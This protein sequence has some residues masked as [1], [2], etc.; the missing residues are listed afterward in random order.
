[1][2]G[3]LRPIGSLSDPLGGGID[4]QRLGAA[5][6]MT[7]VDRELQ[8]LSDTVHAIEDRTKRVT[9]CERVTRICHV[10]E[11]LQHRS[12]LGRCDGLG[13]Q[14]GL[15]SL[16]LPDELDRALL[17]ERRRR[18][19]GDDRVK[20]SLDCGDGVGIRPRC[21]RRCGRRG[22]IVLDYTTVVVHISFS[23][24]ALLRS[25]PAFLYG[26]D[27]QTKSPGLFVQRRRCSYGGTRVPGFYGYDS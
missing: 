20:R 7:R 24:G 19:C 5:L 23:A 10:E 3:Q 18:D 21:R 14:L 8:I 16:T 22:Y 13:D 6:D 15:D 9:E 27:L 1:M 2:R 17:L 26:R 12:R 25:A 11:V 4:G